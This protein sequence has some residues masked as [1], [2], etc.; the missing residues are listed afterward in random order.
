MINNFSIKAIIFDLG[1]VLVD[2]DHYRAAGEMSRFTKKSAEEI[3]A[4][5]FDSAL[6]GL[7]EEGRV[8]PEKFFLKVREILDLQLDYD[9][10]VPIWNEIFFL[11]PKN[12]E[13]YKLAKSLKEDYKIALL[14]NI[15]V[16]HF[17]YLKKNFSIFDVFHNIII[18]CEIGFRKPHPVIY[19]KTLEALEVSPKQVFYTDDRAELI[20]GA[21]KL[22]INGFVF[23]DIG[24]LKKDFFKTGIK[25]LD[26]NKIL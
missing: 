22:G 13:V 14:S 3:F 19:K 5:F 4:L 6:T 11:S 21:L 12:Q 9:K 20:Q 16:L 25:I 15:N 7:F 1:G 10:F 8:S 23:R 26:K 24:Q 2:F 17:E 18:S